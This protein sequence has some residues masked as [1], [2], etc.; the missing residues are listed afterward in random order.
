MVT[1]VP[2]DQWRPG[3]RPP[4]PPPGDL[5]I[6]PVSHLPIGDGWTVVTGCFAARPWDS[7]RV[8]GQVQV[9]TAWLAAQWVLS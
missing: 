9:R 3:A 2:A 7:C 4:T 1:T 8:L 6:S 5:S